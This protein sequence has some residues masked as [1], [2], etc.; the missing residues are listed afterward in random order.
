MGYHGVVKDLMV[1]Y[2]TSKVIL[3]RAGVPALPSQQCTS[4][5]SRGQG[6]QFQA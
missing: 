5:L 4:G 6:K 1:W 3:W 2:R